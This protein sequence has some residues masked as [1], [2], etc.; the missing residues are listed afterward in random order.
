MKRLTL[1]LIIG[2]IV[3]GCDDNQNQNKSHDLVIEISDQGI[4]IDRNKINLPTNLNKISSILGDPTGEKIQTQFEISKAKSKF[5]A[6]PNNIFTYDNYGILVY[7]SPEEQVINS[8]SIDF[9]KQS[10]DFSPS[11]PFSGILKLHGTIIDGNTS[12]AELK[13]ISQIEISESSFKVIL[14]RSNTYALA[15]EFNN[16]KNS[17]VG[18]SIEANIPKMTNDKGWADSDIESFKKVIASIEQIKS[19]S[20][21]YNF[22]LM[23]FVDCYAKKVSTTITFDKMINPDAEV[24]ARVA[25]IMEDCVIQVTK[26]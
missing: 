6:V 17:L 5:G 15:F 3:F 7:Q 19:L 22:E 16:D 8:I 26:K 21:Q 2:I 13:K 1:L 4:F 20:I 12:I 25:K 10:Y 9:E 11:N 24:Q 23:D 18:F 14:A